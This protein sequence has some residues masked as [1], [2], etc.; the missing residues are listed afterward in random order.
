M[1]LPLLLVLTPMSSPSAW[2]PVSRNRWSL[3]NP[4]G[5]VTPDASAIAWSR[6]RLTALSSPFLRTKRME[7]VPERREKEGWFNVNLGVVFGG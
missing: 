7:A 4:L 2:P 3:L 6:T 1:L 5:T